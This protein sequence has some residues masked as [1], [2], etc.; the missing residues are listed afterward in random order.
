MANKTERVTV[1]LNQSLLDKINEAA[2]KQKIS[3]SELFRKAIDFQIES[4]QDIPSAVPYSVRVDR[5]MLDK[6]Y[7]MVEQG[8]IESKNLAV[9]YAV[10]NY[11]EKLDEAKK[12]SAV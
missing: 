1:R 11:I 10:I 3:K 12:S 8:V 5:G 2:E 9:L 7:G 6:L 4:E